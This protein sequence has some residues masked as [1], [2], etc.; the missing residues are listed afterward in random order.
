MKIAVFLPNWVGDA[1]MATPA[2]RA[3]RRHFSSAHLVGVL[4]PYVAG[5]LAGAPWLDGQLLLDEKGPWAR[6]WP[7]VS[8]ALRRQR[9]DLAVLFPNSFRSALVACLGGCRRRVGYARGG[10]SWLLTDRLPPLRAADGTFTPSPIID[11]Y[12]LLVEHLGCP[13]PGHR[14]ELFTSPADEQAADAVWE[15]GG[16]GRYREVIC[17]NPGAAF[18]SAKHWPAES[19]AHL[20]QGLADKRGSG[21]LVLCGPAER[22]LAMQIE[23]L[24]CRRA[25]HTLADYALSLGLTKACVRRA[26][27]LITTDS[28]PRHFA[29]AFDRPVVTLFG[30]THIAWTETYHPAAVHLQKKVDC[31]PC[32][33]RV[34]PLDHR[35]MRGLT[36][37][38][39]F[40]AAAEL[41][42]CYPARKAAS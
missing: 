28:G 23:N 39:V 30:P 13:T 11:A 33:R 21:V 42:T 5:V 26:D 41:L 25:V 4:R 24:A 20:A 2:L 1:V 32:Q 3:L 19:F 8:L 31:G 15:R 22:T 16:L 35:C 40:T 34:C 36:P 14:M 38:E 27:L 6:R 9:P 17:L 18:G 12:N 37:V 7:A 10:R 29:A